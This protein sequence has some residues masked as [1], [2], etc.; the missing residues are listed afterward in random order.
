L[1]DALLV[2]SVFVKC[3][4][5]GR[6]STHPPDIVKGKIAVLTI[7]KVCIGKY[8]ST[9]VDMPEDIRYPRRVIIRQS[10]RILARVSMPLLADVRVTGRENFPDKG[11]L[12]VVGNHTAAMEVV[13]MTVYAPWTIEF[14]G[15][16]DIPHEKL[17]VGIINAYGFIPVFRGN[18]MPSSMKAGV[19]VLKQNGIL[20][21]FPEG[22]IWEPSIRRAQSGVAWLSYH[23]QAPIL[24]IGFGSMQGA[25]K[26]MF[27]FER[28]TL[29]MNV[30]GVIPPIQAQ[31]P[32]KSRKQHFQDEAN[33]IMDVVWELIPE[34]DRREQTIKDEQFELR[35]KVEDQLGKPVPVPRELEMQHGQA[36]S[37]FTHRKT[38]INNF[39]QNMNMP[40]VTP[41]THLV[42]Q[43]GIDEII[44]ATNAILKHLAHENPYYFTYRYGQREGRAM[45]AG[46]RELYNLALWAKE[47]SLRLKVTPIRHFEEIATG[48]EVVLDRPEEF[49]KW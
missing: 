5:I 41:L 1:N 33:R 28:P 47:N 4:H 39:I 8:S 20:G 49:V 2:L 35:I 17:M 15:S 40:E 32:H 23:A 22:G 3:T 46:I 19:E 18:A 30:G 26:K 31:P 48:R 14:M 13:L 34:E 12:L 25:I 36:F 16:I 21:I 42:D 45:E 29:K 44:D 24:P 37:K 7:F 27:A 38:L 6:N 11:P 43:P 9:L 10:L